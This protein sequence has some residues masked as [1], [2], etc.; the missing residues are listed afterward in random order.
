MSR[1]VYYSFK[2]N[3]EENG[4]ILFVGNTITNATTTQNVRLAPSS[5]Y[6][7]T[8]SSKFRALSGTASTNTS[9]GSLRVTGGIGIGGNLYVGGGLAVSGNYNN[10]TVGA[11]SATSANFLNFTSTGTLTVEATA[12]ILVTKTGASGV[13]SHDFTQSNV[14]Y[15]TSMSGNFT[16][17][18]TN[19]PTTN[20]RIITINLILIQSATPYYASV[21]QIDSVAQTIRWAGNTTSPTVTANKTEIQTF[22]LVRS[23]GVWTVYGGISSFG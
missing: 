23:A 21:L 6:V 14:W 20:D 16:A 22:T 9:T 5:G 12:D 8:T 19:T 11:N 7:V 3:T 15:H 17:N 4:T 18:I 10:I 13:V 2:G 1:K